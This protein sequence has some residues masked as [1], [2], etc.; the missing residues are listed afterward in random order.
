MTFTERVKRL[1]SEIG[2][3]SDGI[4]G[5]DTITAFERR[6]YGYDEPSMVAGSFRDMLAAIAQSEVGTKE[7]GNNGGERVRLY[8]SATW[9]APAP[10]PWCAAFVCWCVREA[11]GEDQKFTRPRTAGAW[12]FENWARG[13]HGQ[14]EGVQLIKPTP[15]DIHAGDIVVFTFSHIGIAVSSVHNGKVE[16]VEG[17][18]NAAGSR[19]GDG[20][21]RKS[22]S[23]DKI[24]SVIRFTQ[25]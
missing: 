21:W 3:T 9:L 14:V 10:W 7:E 23:L 4:I 17:N 13:K 6:I 15:S 2:V 18:T 24:R 20:V 8:Q 5:N 25:T 19:E 22:R 12:D 11:M 1:Q 16:T